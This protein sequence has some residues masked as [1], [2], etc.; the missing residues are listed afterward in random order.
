MPAASEVYKASEVR[1]TASEVYKASEVRLT[2]S[3][4]YKVSEVCLRRVKFA[5]QIVWNNFVLLTL[6]KKCAVLAKISLQC[7]KFM[8][9]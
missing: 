8:I 3:E 2:A 5:G 4:V 1:L 7:K 9:Q 6:I